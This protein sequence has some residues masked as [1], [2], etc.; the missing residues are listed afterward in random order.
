MESQQSQESPRLGPV[1]NPLEAKVVEESV[2][3]KKKQ[4]R[5]H[6]DHIES[7]LSVAAGAVRSSDD[8]EDDPGGRRVPSRTS[9]SDSSIYLRP[10]T[11]RSLESDHFSYVHSRN[12]ADL[13]ER[14]HR[15]LTRKADNSG[16]AAAPGT[17][18]P[19]SD[20]LTQLVQ[21]PD[22]VY[23]ILF[24]WLLVYCLLLFPQLDVNRL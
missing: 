10:H 17:H 9:H 5:K 4:K 2:S 22:L 16:E 14:R 15:I 3:S 12:A 20:S 23:F 13:D 6:V 18:S 7:A 8:L 1:A 21:Q 11:N 19:H 24:L